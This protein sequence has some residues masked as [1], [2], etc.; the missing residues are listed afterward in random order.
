M[1]FEAETSGLSPILVDGA[2]K[3]VSRIC[4]FMF[5]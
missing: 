1:V 5:V 2:C 4:G 3:S